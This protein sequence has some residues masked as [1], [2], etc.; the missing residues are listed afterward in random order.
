M[1]SQNKKIIFWFFFAYFAH[2]KGKAK[3]N[4]KM[5]FLSHKCY[6]YISLQKAKTNKVEPLKK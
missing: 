5:S 2:F 4:A 1:N 6:S 3:Q